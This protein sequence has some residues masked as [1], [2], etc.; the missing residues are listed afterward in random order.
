MIGVIEFLFF[1]SLLYPRKEREIHQGR[2][3]IDIAM[4]NGAK[5]GIFVRL[6][7]IRDFPCAYVAFECK[8]Y[9]TDVANPEIDQL[10]GRFSPNR[11]KVGFLCCRQVTTQA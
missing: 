11:G 6:H 3:R 1:P 8:N 10:A 2:K 9:S 4:E 5:T 7:Q